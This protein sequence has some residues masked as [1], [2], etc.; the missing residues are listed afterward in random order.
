MTNPNWQYFLGNGASKPLTEVPKAPAWRQFMTKKEFGIKDSKDKAK[1]EDEVKPEDDTK[2]PS[3]FE[4]SLKRWEKL[5][6][7]AKQDDRGKERGESFRLDDAYK[8]DILNAVNAA[9]HCPS[10]LVETTHFS[11]R[12]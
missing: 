10:A 4:A 2:K 8:V 7:L 1:P 5:Q 6:E 11:G 3:A 9:I 12:L